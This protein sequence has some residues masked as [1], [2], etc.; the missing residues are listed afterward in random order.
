MAPCSAAP[1][2]LPEQELP[3]DRAWRARGAERAEPEKVRTDPGPGDEG[4]RGAEPGSAHAGAARGQLGGQQISHQHDEGERRFDP[5]VRRRTDHQARER[6]GTS[7]AAPDLETDDRRRD[8]QDLECVQRGAADAMQ[9]QETGSEGED[10]GR[11]DSRSLAAEGRSA[12]VDQNRRRGRSQHARQAHREG[13]GTQDLTG[14]P[15][16]PKAERRLV[17]EQLAGSPHRENGSLPHGFHDGARIGD[18]VDAQLRVRQSSREDRGDPDGESD[19]C[20]ESAAR[21]VHALSMASRL[22]Y[23]EGGHASPPAIELPSC[24]DSWLSSP[25][26]PSPPSPPQRPPPRRSPIPSRFTTCWRWTASRIPS[27]RR[28]G[29]GWSSS[30]APRTSRPTG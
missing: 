6:P 30:S 1:P 12:E 21:H 5:G 15:H 14:Q 27:P 23:T 18:L 4:Y 13:A 11:Q 20:S 7:A 9:D 8:E 22:K 26:W 10:Q 2:V 16:Q 25:S 24:A 3:D 17:E 29:T 28:R 19:G